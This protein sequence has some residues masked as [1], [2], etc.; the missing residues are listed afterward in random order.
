MTS[1]IKDLPHYTKYVESTKYYVF[2]GS[3]TMQYL[4]TKC[5]GIT[6]DI[7]TD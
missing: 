6:N 2:S 5:L 1:L 7:Q 4:G 3:T